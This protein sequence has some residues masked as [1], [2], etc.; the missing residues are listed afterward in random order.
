M[1]WCVRDKG[2]G[3]PEYDRCLGN[4]TIKMH[5]NGRIE[6]TKYVGDSFGFVD[7]CHEDEISL[8][9]YCS[10]TRELGQSLSNDYYLMV[11][12]KMKV[13]RNDIDAYRVCQLVDRNRLVNVYAVCNIV[14]EVHVDE[15]LATQCSQNIS[16]RGR[17]NKGK[18][19]EQVVHVEEE[20]HVKDEVLATLCS[21]NVSKRGRGN[22]GTAKEQTVN[23]EEVYDEFNDS[24][25][26]DY[27]PDSMSSESDDDYFDE[28]DGAIKEDDELFEIN[29]D[30]EVKDFG[31]PFCSYPKS[32]HGGDNMAPIDDG[33]DDTEELDTPS[34]SDTDD[35][36]ASKGKKK[37]KKNV[38]FNE[39]T[40]MLNPVF[41]PGME[42]KTHA[43]FRDAVKEHG[44]KL[45][46]II[47]FKQ[48][49][50]KKVQAVCEGRKDCPW[51]IYGAF[52]KG[53]G[54]FRVKHYVGEHTCT[55]GY[56]V[57]WVSTNWIVRHYSERIAKNPG[58]P[59]RSLTDEIEAEW[60]VHVDSCGEGEEKNMVWFLE[61][62]KE[63]L[64][65]HNSGLYTFMTDKQK[66]LIDAVGELFPNARHRFCV[67][68]MYN[69]FKGE[70]KG[71]VLKEILWKAARATTMA[72]FTKAMQEMKSVDPKA[73][74]WLNA[75]PAINWS[76]SHFDTFP[77]CDILLNNLSESF[78]S[79]IL[80]A[81]D[82]P[83]ITMLEK[84]R[85][86]LMETRNKRKEVMLRCKDPI[87]PKIRRR[88]DKLREEKG[89]IPRYFG[90]HQFQVEGPNEQFR[91]DLKKGMCGCRKWELSGIPCV[92]AC[93]AYN[94]LELEPMDFVHDCYK[95]QTYL[96][97][98]E[99]VM[100][101]INGRE[102]W[103]S[104]GN[105]VLLPPDVKKRA[106][107]PKKVRRREP[108]EDVPT[109]STKLS[110]KGMKMTCTQCGQTGHNKRGCKKESNQMEGQTRDETA[111]PT[112]LAPT[113]PSN[114][115]IFIDL[116]DLFNVSISVPN[117]SAMTNVGPVWVGAGGDSQSGL[118]SDG[119]STVGTNTTALATSKKKTKHCA[120]VDT[121]PNQMQGM[122]WRGNRVYL[123]ASKTAAKQANNATT[124]KANKAS[125]K[126]VGSLSDH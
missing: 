25:S 15:V 111:A 80:G 40:D 45:G 107:R 16:K 64:D 35:D 48:S 31:V 46:R 98:Y 67:R 116:D 9:E 27:D 102:L 53:D 78:N 97:T 96:N 1:V 24:D 92:H 90:H 101:P 38:L 75:R 68:H 34:E 118:T 21:K 58:W 11:N 105:P 70:F 39:K 13:V 120:I 10:M 72:S 99:H 26:D 110:K 95:V 43:I 86:M 69:N 125:S 50:T 6:G 103:P 79:A 49:D 89:W 126:K 100:G 108:D 17:R 19:K 73:Y 74:E 60:T 41:C 84:I 54:V 76:R 59:I 22:K 77:K 7:Y 124:P 32:T 42:F 57:P 18:G 36:L 63:D 88:L 94:K 61:L 44:V 82:K 85:T 47:K 37:K 93:A 87:C 5:Y 122:N 119:G 106:G 123:A 56:N 112:G 91:V 3:P 71:L 114:E 29:V 65:V 12:G 33:S 115:E 52:V 51:F 117:S 14:E 4:F 113:G 66:G 2:G 83:I 55:R 121:T 20:I 62:L 28:S 109:S 81:R 23:V 104:T 8:L 30:K